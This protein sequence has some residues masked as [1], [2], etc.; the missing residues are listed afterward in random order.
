M[1]GRSRSSIPPS[2][3]PSTPPITRLCDPSPDRVMTSI[4][5]VRSLTEEGT[6]VEI[7]D[8]FFGLFHGVIEAVHIVLR[9][10]FSDDD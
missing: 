9:A 1:E 8:F 2:R 7:L 6:F 4:P 10:A 3:V 5:S